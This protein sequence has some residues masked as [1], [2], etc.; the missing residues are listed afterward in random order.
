MF[1]DVSFLKKYISILYYT[2]AVCKNDSYFQAIIN[3]LISLFTYA[4]TP[5][6]REACKK[7]CC[8]E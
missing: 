1:K 5:V 2:A 6:H 8:I 3:D 7:S 4:C